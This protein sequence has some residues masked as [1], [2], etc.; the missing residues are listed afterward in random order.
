MAAA[1][2]V[3]LAYLGILALMPKHVFWAPDEGGRFIQMQTMHWRNGLTYALPY[4]GQRLDPEAYFFPGG[5]RPGQELAVFPVLHSDGDME[6][7]WPIWFC[8]VARLGWELFGFPGIYMFPLLSGWLTA[9]LAGRLLH[10][11]DRRLAPAAIFL[12]G[13]ASPLCF[14][15]Q[16]FWDH[17]PATF[18]ALLAAYF[19]VA[20]PQGRASGLLAAATLVVGAMMLRFEMLAF[21]LAAI[22]A[23]LFRRSSELPDGAKVAAWRPSRRTLVIL[24]PAA[25][26][27]GGLFFSSLAPRHSRFLTDPAR[28]AFNA[29][30]KLL[31]LPQGLVGLLINSPAN[32][33]PN[34]PPAF[35]WATLIAVL[36]ACL[37]VLAGGRFES[38]AVV[39]AGAL[40]LALSATVNL[41]TQ[42]YRALHGLLP[43]A[44]W[45][46]LAIVALPNAWRSADVRLRTLT[47]LTLSYLLFGLAA[48]FLVYTSPEGVPS[49]TLEWGPRYLLTA[50][51]LLAVLALWGIRARLLAPPRLAWQ[52]LVVVLAAGLIFVGVRQEVRGLL[53]LHDNRE[54]IARWDS[55]LRGNGP[56]VTNL[57]WL[58]TAVAP[59][60]V[61][62]EM[63]FV[64]S[65]A[66]L[67]DWLERAARHGVRHF[68]FATSTKPT[69][70]GTPTVSVTATGS[71]AFSKLTV[72]RFLI[73]QSP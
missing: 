63:Y 12:V 59:L 11:F 27:L 46:V 45:A 5:A 57:W 25:I 20:H 6:L 71:E 13:L 15:S 69:N 54:L 37:G 1:C 55:A 40:L 34:L 14:Y 70:V 7:H 30:S 2:A 22:A 35:E 53:M 50:Y 42:D 44:P 56:I 66:D 21:A 73:A 24:I 39:S 26:V 32:E 38:S 43:V 31:V 29:A 61:S 47:V 10:S 51:P 19:L 72:T 3:L 17:T 8:L 49:N 67:S 62:N 18:L 36:A 9:V 68:T 52:R 16:T 4:A 41:T 58:P 33:G 28:I 60:F 64:A 65:P 48:N 23:A